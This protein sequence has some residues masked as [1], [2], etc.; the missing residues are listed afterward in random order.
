MAPYF[1]KNLI[2][3]RETRA[4]AKPLL[5]VLASLTWIQWA[6]FLS[7][8]VNFPVWDSQSALIDSILDGLPG[9]AMGSI[10]SPYH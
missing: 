8:P 7:G 5:S 9:H 1:L 2:P 6:M 4:N 10:F 3:R